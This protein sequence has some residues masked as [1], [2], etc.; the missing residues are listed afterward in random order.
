MA[1]Q[2]K[3]VYIDDEPDLCFMVKELL[4]GT[5]EFAVTTST[6]P[7]Q[8]ENLV[9]QVSPHLLLLDI[10]MPKR[11]GTDIIAAIKKD[12]AFKKLPIIV[13]S[14]KGEM[15]F[16]KKKQEFK[17]QPNNPLAKDRGQL[18]EG[19]SAEVLAEG[20]GVVD[21]ISKPFTKDILLQVIRDVM[22]KCYK[23]EDSQE[24]SA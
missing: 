15:I 21:Y 7:L 16:D 18:P 13:V 8:A 12:D 11:K 20:Y 22:A 23:A 17:W 6:D 4:E 14:G 19:K 9:R 1:E 3:I 10:V 24:E 2:K 5:G